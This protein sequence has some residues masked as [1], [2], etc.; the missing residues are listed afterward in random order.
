VVFAGARNPDNATHLHDLAKTHPGKVYTV[1]LDLGDVTGNQKTIEEVK[2]K[3]G[4][5][6]VLIAN[7]GTL[8]QRRR[9]GMVSLG[10]HWVQPYSTTLTQCLKRRRKQCGTTLRYNLS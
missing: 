1:K 10:F 3:A 7:A 5:L 2:K 9:C 6:D 4:K 8:E